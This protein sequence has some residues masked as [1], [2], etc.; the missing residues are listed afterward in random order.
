MTVIVL[1]KYK[2]TYYLTGDGRCTARH[3]IASDEVTKVYKATGKRKVKG[4]ITQD[5]YIFGGAG[6]ASSE[7]LIKKALA[8]TRD[9]HKLQR[10]LKDSKEFKDHLVTT[11]CFV[12]TKKFGSYLLCIEPQGFLSSSYVAIT[13]AWEDSSL[14]QVIGSGSHHVSALLS[15]YENPTPKVVEAC[16]KQA[17]KV[18]CTIGGKISSVDLKV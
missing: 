7:I 14:P 12:V 5:E 11:H 18:N 2:G 15:Q 16:I 13:I 3:H 9:P 4:K 1:S 6:C 17:Y 10:L 8:K